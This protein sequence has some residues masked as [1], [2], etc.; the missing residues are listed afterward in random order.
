[1]ANPIP[2]LMTDFIVH[3]RAQA[4]TEVKTEH[5]QVV[6]EVVR[7][8]TALAEIIAAADAAGGPKKIEDLRM[9]AF[10]AHLLSSDDSAKVQSWRNKLLQDGTVGIPAPTPPQK[11]HPSKA[12]KPT[13]CSDD[14][15]DDAARSLLKMRRITKPAV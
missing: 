2:L 1:M 11:K 5:E 13:P 7:G 12:S 3:E 4:S 9:C 8:S 15:I 14:S 6:T 10:W